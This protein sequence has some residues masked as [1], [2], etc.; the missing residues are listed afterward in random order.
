MLVR[1]HCCEASKA[2]AVKPSKISH[3]SI[4]PISQ[5]HAE[6]NVKINNVVIAFESVYEIL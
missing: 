4:D 1:W 2:S 3:G 6:S 5:L